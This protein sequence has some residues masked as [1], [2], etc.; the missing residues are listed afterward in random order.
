MNQ[1]LE[2]TFADMAPYTDEWGALF[3]ASSPIRNEAGKTV[4][5][6]FTNFSVDH[7]AFLSRQTFS[8]VTLFCGLFILF[9]VIRLSAF[10]RSLFQEFWQIFRIVLLIFLKN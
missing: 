8:A 3:D 2:G 6:L 4:A 1:I 10:N 7:V 5:V 9:V